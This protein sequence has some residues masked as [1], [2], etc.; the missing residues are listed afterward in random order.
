MARGIE[1]LVE[2]VPPVPPA[3][4]GDAVAPLQRGHAPGAVD[5]VELEVLLAGEIGPPRGV[6]HRAV[7][8]RAERGAAGRIGGGLHPRVP[9]G[10][11]GEPDRGRRGDPA[12]VARR[13]DYTPSGRRSRRTS[14]TEIPWAAC[15][16]RTFSAVHVQ[17]AVRVEQTVV[18]V[19]VVDGEQAMGRAGLAGGEREE[20]HAVVVH[21]RLAELV[22]HAVARVRLEGGAVRDRI[23]PG[24][25]HLRDVAARDHQRVGRRHRHAGEAQRAPGP[26]RGSQPSEAGRGQAGGQQAPARQPHPEHVVEGGHRR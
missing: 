22:V 18:R 8:H 7:A 24:V 10:R 12:R 9:G 16:F 20:A 17:H 26:G 23:A 6:A 19:L 5:E 4:L 2:L 14:I 15:D 1:A 21:A 3:P 11:P 25:E 13:A